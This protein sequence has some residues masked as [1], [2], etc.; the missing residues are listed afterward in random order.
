MAEN[1]D[2]ASPIPL[3]PAHATALAARLRILEEDCGEVE[4]CLKGYEGIGFEYVGTLSES[5]RR[6]AAATL[7]EILKSLSRLQRE[8]GLPRQQIEL[9]K[10]LNAHLSH[11]WV[12]LHESKSQSLR[13]YGA[14][15]DG[16]R[17][18]LDPR[19]DQLLKLLNRMREVV[20]ENKEY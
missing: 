17:A 16:L 14:I 5:G 15:P 1:A 19:M 6:A 2:P 18:F 8:L 11:M 13:G 3:S 4:R 7:K 9:R 10:L 12:T 20:G